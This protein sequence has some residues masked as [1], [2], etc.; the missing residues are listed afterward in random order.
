[1]K[2]KREIIILIVIATVLIVNGNTQADFTFGTP[3]PVPNIN[4]K[5][6]DGGPRISSDDLTLFF[7]SNRPGGEGNWDLWV[8]TRANKDDSWGEPENFGPIIN[9]PFDDAGP[10]ITTKCNDKRSVRVWRDSVGGKGIAIGVVS[11]QTAARVEHGDAPPEPSHVGSLDD[12][13]A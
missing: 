9:T 7:V 3:I 8:S 1:M 5:Y 2:R 4:S 12:V 6:M 11:D 13:I 10:S